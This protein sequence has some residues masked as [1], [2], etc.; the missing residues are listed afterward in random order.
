MSVSACAM[1]FNLNVKEVPGYSLSLM[2]KKNKP[3]P[4]N[5]KQTPQLFLRKQ[6]IH[7]VFGRQ[8]LAAFGTLHHRVVFTVSCFH[9]VE[10][11]VGIWE[12]SESLT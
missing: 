5:K 7:L 4:N 6:S 3:K 8:T 10:S 12:P 2:K 9:C 11:Q 1:A